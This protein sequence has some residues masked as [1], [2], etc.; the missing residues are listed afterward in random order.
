MTP[1]TIRVNDKDYR[2]FDDGTGV[3][4]SAASIETYALR[5]A[6]FLE[7][8]KS[9]I[10]DFTDLPG[11]WAVDSIYISSPEISEVTIELLDS[12]G[13][14]FYE[15]KLTR[16]QLPKAFPTVLLNSTLK[17]KLTASRENI[18]LFIMYLKPAHLAYSK[19]F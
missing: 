9:R 6:F 13:Y 3:K 19:D 7:T 5:R 2:I 15:D 11:F 10:V 16:N 18:N 8:G 1:E 17:L 14:T 4:L 12:N